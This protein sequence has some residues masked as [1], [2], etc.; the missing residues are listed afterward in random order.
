MT[1][2]ELEQWRKQH[3]WTRQEAG[4]VLGCG[5]DHIYN[6]ERRGKPISQCRALLCW[7]LAFPKVKEGVLARLQLP[8]LHRKVLTDEPHV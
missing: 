3:A 6:M 5:G 7:L 4:Q 8:H 2:S 1:G